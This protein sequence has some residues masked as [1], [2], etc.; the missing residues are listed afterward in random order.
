MWNG[1]RCAFYISL[2]VDIARWRQLS[3]C[4]YARQTNKHDDV[5]EWKHFRVTGPL[6][7][8]FT[9]H[10]WIPLT[11]AS[12]A[13]LWCFLW[14]GPEHNRN[15]GDLRRHRAHYDVTV[16]NIGV[17]DPRGMA[18]EHCACPM[19]KLTN[20]CSGL[21]MGTFNR[22]VLLGS[23][24]KGQRYISINANNHHYRVAKWQGIISSIHYQNTKS[25][26]LCKCSLIHMDLFR[27]CHH[28][29]KHNTHG[30]DTMAW[31]S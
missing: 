7:G 31:T 5:I 14:S 8:E 24:Q 30:K 29:W 27:T 15:A 18:D 6:C 1:C 26:P 12:D 9:C 16:M 2:H 3:Q 4:L 22:C 10:R 25:K 21:P 23:V 11:K 17:W 13:V 19:C 20:D 28:N